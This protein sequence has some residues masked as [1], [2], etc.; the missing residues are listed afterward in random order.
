MALKTL[1]ESRIGKATVRLLQSDKG[2]AGIVLLDGTVRTRLEGADLEDVWR[3]MEKEAAACGPG[4]FGF[5]G[6][7]ARFLR[8]FPGGFKAAAYAAS[9]R[10]YKVA[11]KQKLD[12][13]APLEEALTGK[14]FGEAVLAVYRAT[15]LLSPF[16]KTRMADALRGSA[17]DEFIRAAA[18]FALGEGRPA[19]AAMVHALRA[20]D[21]AK[22]TALTYLP[23]LWRPKEHMF[24]KPEVTK[25]FAERVGHTFAI[26][27]VAQAEYEVYEALQ[28]LIKETQLQIE[29]LSPLDRIDVQSFIW[30]V[31]EYDVSAEKGV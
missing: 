19:L 17:A 6:A 24:L 11:A 12:A 3:R 23:F 7:K 13:L 5:D 10:N 14:G 9:E 4:F 28:D 1:R 20:S 22:W 30:V 15:N 29:D 31:G 25:E 8:I 16:E 27:Y 18:A 2:Y 26:R 21:V